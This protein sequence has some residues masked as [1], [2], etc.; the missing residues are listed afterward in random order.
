MGGKKRKADALPPK[1]ERKRPDVARRKAL[2]RALSDFA[3]KVSF[4][5]RLAPE[6][7]NVKTFIQGLVDDYV[8][9]ISQ[10]AVRGS[11]VFNEVLHHF[12]SEGRVPEDLDMDALLRA[13][14]TGIGGPDIVR[15]INQ[16]TLASHPPIERHQGDWQMVTYAVNQYKTAFENATVYNFESRLAGLISAW[17]NKYRSTRTRDGA[18][19]MILRHVLHKPRPDDALEGQE[20]IFADY[21]RGRIAYTGAP[22]PLDM[23]AQDLVLYTHRIL[24]CYVEFMVPGGFTMA[25]V[26]QVKRHHISIDSTALYCIIRRIYKYFGD[27]SPTWVQTV[28]QMDRATFLQSRPEDAYTW[29]QYAW[30]HF[31]SYLDLKREDF[32]E[33]IVTNGVSCSVMFRR[34]KREKVDEE[35]LRKFVRDAECVVAI[36]PGRANLITA[37]FVV[38]GREIWRILTRRAYYDSFASQAKVLKAWDARLQDI[39]QQFGDYSLRTSVSWLREGHIGVYCTQFA[40]LW[41]ERGS[42]RRARVRLDILSRKRSCLDRFFQG[43]RTPGQPDP[44]V[45]YGAARLRSHG[46]KGELA[47]PV[48]AA[49]MAC[50]RKFL[51]VKVDE[52]LTTKRHSVCHSDMHPVR[53]WREGTQEGETRRERKARDVRGLKFCTKCK[54]FVNRDRDACRCI[55]EIGRSEER[56]QYLR[57]EEGGVVVAPLDK[58]PPRQRRT[59]P[60][61]A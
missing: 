54:L 38:G 24:E 42:K 26:C 12:A 14:F 43:F 8:L 36:D 10:M 46:T 47:V 13:C 17:A 51:T 41:Y 40:R 2:R 59:R 32:G 45:F 60:G 44:V 50:A 37:L 31:Y 11:L 9:S 6:C 7:P 33:R 4:G 52:Y 21:L 34:T 58:L 55:L 27:S 22:D 15:D 35:V 1:T 25:P 49:Y 61:I 39:D 56:P 16:S 19:G 23:R 57:R 18:I 53:N 3:V 20:R 48:K 5:G 30:M 29:R 28:A